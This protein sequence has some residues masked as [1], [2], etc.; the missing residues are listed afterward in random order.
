MATEPKRPTLNGESAYAIPRTAAEWD[1]LQLLYDGF[2][3]YQRGKLFTTDLGAPKRILELGTGNGAWAVQAAME[4]P[5][6][7]VVA[8]DMAPLHPSF[9]PPK[10]FKF[11]QID[12]LEGFPF[13]PASFDVIHARFLLI[14]LPEPE[15]QVQRILNLL[16]PGGFLLVADYVAWSNHSHHAPILSA[17]VKTLEQKW[18]ANGMAPWFPARLGN[19]L[20]ATQAF[21]EINI[22]TVTLPM[23]P[24][25]V[26]DPALRKFTTAMLGSITA[27]Y[28]VWHGG[29]IP[30]EQ[31]EAYIREVTPGGDWYC[32]H[33]VLFV[34]AK[35]KAEKRLANETVKAKL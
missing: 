7:E 4:Y 6:A 30:T 27:A 12:I 13:E 29:L 9:E 33:D 5:D 17:A 22:M 11:V 10:N 23:N 20:R 1:R 28:P 16:A 14:H 24:A 34:T 15:K 19:I 3:A 25:L 31:H 21:D 32:E 2:L 18:Q 8:V 35:K 26:N